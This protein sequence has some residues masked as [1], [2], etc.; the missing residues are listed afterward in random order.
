MAEQE[1]K[2]IHSVAKAIR[3]LDLLTAAGQPASLTE[4]YQK[5]G[6]PKST[7]H[8]LLS[9]MRESGLIEQTPNGRYWL[10]I[11]LFEYGCAVSNSWDIG[12]IARPHMQNICTELGESVFLSVFD[13]AAVV[14]LA[15][16]E[17]RASLR[18]VSEV[19]ARLPVHCTSQGKL[20]LANSSPGRVPP[21]PHAHRAQGLHAPTRSPRRSSSPPS[22]PASASR[23]YAVENGEYK[24]GLRSVSAPIHDVTGEVRYAIGCVGMFRQIQSDEFLHAIRLVC[25]AADTISR[26]I[27]YHG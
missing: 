23:G 19:G 12:A 18:V 26:A 9:T 2:T 10:G 3:L 1:G 14:T 21:H 20:F 13:R 17:S 6:W 8:G 11:R 5:T 25:A 16:E 22:S 4:L 15:E 7:I 24:I 27:G